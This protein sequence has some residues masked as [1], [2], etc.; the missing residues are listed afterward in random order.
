V[1]CDVGAYRKGK[2]QTHPREKLSSS[3]DIPKNQVCSW[4]PRSGENFWNNT[5]A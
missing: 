4:R 5:P 2:T 1:L 3:T